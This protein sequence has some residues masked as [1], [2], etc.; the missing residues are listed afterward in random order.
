MSP[1][2][3]NYP[4]SLYLIQPLFSSYELNPVASNAQASVPIPDG[5]DLDAWIVPPPKELVPPAE[6]VVVEKRRSKKGK[7]KEKEVNG[8]KLGKTSSKK[9]REVELLRDGDVLTPV[10]VDVETPE[11]REKVSQHS[12]GQGVRAKCDCAAESREKGAVKGR[13]VLYY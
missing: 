2:Y 1:P 9:P 8:K 10:D 7:E 3:I 4:K 11:E 6:E 12:I 13:S 5:L